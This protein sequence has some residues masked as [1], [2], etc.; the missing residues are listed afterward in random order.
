MF[1]PRTYRD[2]M[3]GGRFLSFAVTHRETDLWIGVSGGHSVSRMQNFALKRIEDLRRLL[4]GYAKE[5]GKF[6]CA[7]APYI[8][9]EP[10]PSL[11]ERMLGY[12]RKA[13]VGPMASV[14]GV[15]AQEIGE[16]LC[17]EFGV[18]ECI[19]ENGGDIYL[20]IVEPV[21]VSVFAGTSPL[22]YHTA[23]VVEPGFA[24]LGI[25]TSS[26]TVGHSFS[27]GRAD[28]VTIACND[29]GLADAFATAFANRVMGKT[30]IERI[31][32]RAC[33]IPEILGI[34]IIIDDLLGIGA[35]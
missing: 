35:I 17:E 18:D 34:T 27:Y 25:C 11:I 24:P 26:G 14:A 10:A 4:D 1:E 8:P 31:L 30:D 28:A 20:H 19:V 2:R 16:A 23:L 9:K 3:D 7:M 15:F 32:E 33:D 6:L 22:S 21:T 29:A 12:A 13:D 5:D